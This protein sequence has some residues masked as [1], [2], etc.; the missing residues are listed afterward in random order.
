M[1][2]PDPTG[3]STVGSISLT[4]VG[5]SLTTSMRF[6]KGGCFL[7]TVGTLHTWMKCML[8][9]LVVPCKGQGETTR[10]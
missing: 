4:V 7:K 3:S 5:L 9:C 1:R 8:V 6:E 10:R 2:I